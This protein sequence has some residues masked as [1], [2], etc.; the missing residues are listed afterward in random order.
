MLEIATIVVLLCIIGLLFIWISMMRRKLR[1][2]H[3]EIA[4][5]KQACA[6]YENERASW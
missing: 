4:S 6:N 1:D 3:K 2:A 5:W